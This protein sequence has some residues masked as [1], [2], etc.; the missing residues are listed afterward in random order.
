MLDSMTSMTWTMVP[1]AKD[2]HG[3]DGDLAEAIAPAHGDNAKACT[4]GTASNQFPQIG[5]LEVS[6]RG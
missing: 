3:E 4:P 6:P 5:L 1:P 2:S